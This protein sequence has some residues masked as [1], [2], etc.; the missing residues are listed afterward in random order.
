MNLRTKTGLLFIAIASIIIL[1]GGII[2]M[3]ETHY[4]FEMYRRMTYGNIHPEISLLDQH[5]ERAFLQTIAW[6]T[7]GSI[8]FAIS[9]GFFVSKRLTSPLIKMKEIAEEMAE[10]KWDKRL[11]IKG[12]DELSNLGK[13]INKLAE[14]LQE[15]EQLR[16]NMT[17][18]IAHELRTPLAILKSHMEAMLD[19]VWEPTST[20]IKVCFDETER[21]IHLVGEL[22]QL[23]FL[24]S[25]E[26]RLE[27]KREDVSSILR[28]VIQ[29]YEPLFLQKEVNLIHSIQGSVYAMVDRERL[30]QVFMNLLTNALKFTNSGGQVVVQMNKG[31]KELEVK[32]SDNGIGMDE[33]E[34][35]MIFERFYRADKS[36]NREFGGSGIGLTIV[37]RLVEAHDGKIH[38]QS[39]KEKGT[40]VFVKLP[41]NQ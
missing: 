3:I 24:E 20:R 15:Q 16:K 23:T 40:T 17:T 14:Q 41:L 29:T 11:D 19:G 25:P 4:H 12:R 32:I 37:K 7:I 6:T 27:L 9:V 22:E 28:H 18:D 33:Q 5:F 38:I 1:L 26:F 39:K 35:P 10:G 21:M 30:T 13:S 31:L 36:R 34:L 2:L 8:V